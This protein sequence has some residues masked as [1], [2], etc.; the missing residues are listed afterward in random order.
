VFDVL[1]MSGTRGFIFSK[2][3]VYTVKQIVNLAN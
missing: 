2:T 1:H 3:V